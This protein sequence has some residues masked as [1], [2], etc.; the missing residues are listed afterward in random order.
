VLPCYAEWR[1]EGALETLNLSSVTD[2]DFEGVT[3][4]AQSANVDF[5]DCY[6]CGKC[7]A[8]CPM[9]HEMD[10]MPRQLI[11]MLQLGFVDRALNAK[12]PWICASCT[13]CSTRCPQGVDVAAIML[14]VRRAAKKQGLRPVRDA[15]IFDDASVGNIRSFGKSNEAILAA[16]YNL[17]SGHLMQDVLNAPRMAVRG[18]IG[19]KIH[20]VKDR[21]AVR[22]LVDRALGG[23]GQADATCQGDVKRDTLDVSH[24][25][26][27]VS[28]CQGTRPPDTLRPDTPFP[29]DL[30]DVPPG[31]PQ[32]VPTRIPDTR[33][34]DPSGEGS[35]RS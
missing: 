11:R 27:S 23:V 8:G 6:Q 1:K 22:R 21:A 17:L 12:T 19:P 16:K 31:A 3:Q 13:V 10:L 18:M 24:E 14:E 33:I 26:Q 7:T 29:D 4:I 25:P 34:P 2:T 35:E 9:V 28:A 32:I 5:D 15:D 20:S 30:P